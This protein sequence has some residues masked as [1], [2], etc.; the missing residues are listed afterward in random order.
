MKNTLPLSQPSKMLKQMGFQNFNILFVG[1]M[2][3]GKSSVINTM[4][5]VF[6]NQYVEAEKVQEEKV[7]V[8]KNFTKVNMFSEDKGGLC[9]YDIFGYRFDKLEGDGVNVPKSFDNSNYGF[10]GCLSK[11]LDGSMSVNYSEWDDPNYKKM[12]NPNNQ[13]INTMM[14]SMAL[15]ISID[16][17]TDEKSRE[18]NKGLIKMIIEKFGYSPLLIV[19]KCDKYIR[20]KDPNYDICKPIKIETI[21]EDSEIIGIT[22]KFLQYVNI[23]KENM[24]LM[25]NIRFYYPEE[26]RDIINEAL[27]FNALDILKSKAENFVKSQLKDAIIVL[28]QNNEF[29]G[30]FM[31]K[32][33]SEMIF[34]FEPEIHE[35]LKNHHKSEDYFYMIPEGEQSF[36]AK[37]M[38]ANSLMISKLIDPASQ[39]YNTIKIWI[40]DEEKFTEN[41]KLLLKSFTKTGETMKNIS[42]FVTLAELRKNNLKE[43]KGCRFYMP[44]GQ[45]VA[46]EMEENT[47]VEDAVE[48]VQRET[49]SKYDF[50]Y[51]ILQKIEND[52][53]PIKDLTETSELAEHNLKGNECILVMGAKKIEGKFNEKSEVLVT[54]QNTRKVDKLFLND[55]GDLMEKTIIDEIRN[56]LK[57]NQVINGEFNFCR[58]DGNNI[59]IFVERSWTLEDVLVKKEENSFL[60]YYKN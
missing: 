4:I 57:E 16:S 9:F 2:G 51:Q 59:P 33:R 43:C 10:Q 40:R 41:S 35:F 52:S 60:L 46:E 32:D 23:P 18:I 25:S 53:L 26:E 42:M 31:A 6:R 44:T 28:S 21:C 1:P 50:F 45:K 24:V 58:E 54:N 49:N 47:K 15:I 30:W 13:S 39:E 17:M 48:F 20:K 38:M 34:R 11:I 12:Y 27:A 37:K 55:F 22:D 7:T 29:L 5:S 8:T 3:H 36:Y 56:F 14:H 19:T